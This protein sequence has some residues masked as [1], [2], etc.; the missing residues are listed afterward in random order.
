MTNVSVGCKCG[1][2]MRFTRLGDLLH[3]LQVHTKECGLRVTIR[4]ILGPFDAEGKEK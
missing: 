3:W 1:Q 4:G 2:Q